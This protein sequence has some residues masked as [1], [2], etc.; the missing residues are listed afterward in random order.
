MAQISKT[1]EN[2]KGAADQ[3]KHAADNV[4]ELGKRGVDQAADVAREAADRTEETVRRGV[5]VAQRTTGAMSHVQREVAQRT[6]EGAAELGR[7]LVE[8]AN[9][10]TRHNL[11][12]FSALTQAVD[13]DRVSKAVDWDR[14]VKI[15]SEFVRVSLE[16][17]AQLTQRYLE[18]SQAVVT[19][20]VSV[21][22]QEAK[23]AA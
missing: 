17:A 5:Q 20:A 12:T 2:I 23:K 9:E 19:S 15:Q 3:A 13:W 4:A 21:A 6:N 18:V 8:L 1:E 14:V 22:K 11:E 10:Q 16:R 7:A